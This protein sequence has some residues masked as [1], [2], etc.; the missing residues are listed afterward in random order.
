MGGQI[1]NPT[2]EMITT[3]RT[4]HAEVVQVHFRPDA[5][6]FEKVLEYFWKLHDPTTLNRQGNDV[7][8]Q[9]R[10]VVFY[11]NERQKQLAETYK[12]TL[13]QARAFGRPVTTG[14][15]QACQ[16]QGEER[17]PAAVD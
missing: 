15:S 14:Q 10:S 1:P 17:T 13:N 5:I 3:G 16:A 4:G 8:T 6:S 12:K 11:H 9:Y 7:G 2:Y